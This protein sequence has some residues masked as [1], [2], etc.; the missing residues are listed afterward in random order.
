VDGYHVCKYCHVYLHLRRRVDYNEHRTCV[1][2]R[3]LLKMVQVEFAFS[4]G[5][6]ILYI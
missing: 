2:S 1:R 5:T 3:E 6:F 4:I